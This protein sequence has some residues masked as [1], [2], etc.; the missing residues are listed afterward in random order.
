MEIKSTLPVADKTDAG[1]TRRYY[2]SWKAFWKD[3]AYAFSHRDQIRRAMRS[4]SVD[5]VFRERLMLAVTEVNQCRY[6]RAFHIGQAKE[7]G[8]SLDEINIYLQGTIPDDIPEEQ[9]LAVC[10]AQHWAETD[11]FPDRDYLDQVREAYGEEGFEAISIVL[12]MI[13]MGN[14]MGNTWDYFLNKISFRRLGD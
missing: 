6:C 11:G 1:F 5:P 8:I 14:L 9:K 10:Y 12:R 3:L 13:R 7:A 2:S 4:P